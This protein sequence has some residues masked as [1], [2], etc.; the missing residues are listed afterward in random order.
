MTPAVAGAILQRDNR[1]FAVVTRIPGGFVTPHDLETIARV[2]ADYQVPTI[3]ITSGQRIMLIGVK[4]KELPSVH[5][6]LGHL[7]EKETAPCVRYVQACL[8]TETCT[9]GTQDSA[10]L[11]LALEERY[12]GVSF[13]GKL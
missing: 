11:A 12:N 9:Y 5:R 3:K 1:T 8:G 4:E 2:A 7:A 13:P 10:G 6:D